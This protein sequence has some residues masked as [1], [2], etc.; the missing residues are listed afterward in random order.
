MAVEATDVIIIGAGLTGLSLAYELDQQGLDVLVLEARDRIGGRINT[1]T[2]SDGAPVEMGA[3]WFF[4]FFQN[5]FKKMKEHNLELMPQYMKGDTF[6]EFSAREAPRRSR[7]SVD[8]DSDMFRIK[9]GT[10]NIVNTLYS[11]LDPGKVLL[12]QVVTNINKEDNRMVVVTKDKSYTA[13]KVVTTIP[14]QLLAH[15]VKFSPALPSDVMEVTKRTHTWMGDSMK[16]AITY[17]KPFWREK[18]LAGALYSNAGPFVQMYDQTST[19]GT[20]FALVGFMDESIANLPEKERRQRAVKQLVRVFG[21]EAE[22]YLDYKDT[23]WGHEQFTMPRNVGR[24]SRHSNNGHSVY[25]KSYMGGSLY[26][27]GTETSSHAGGYMEGAV[28]SATYLAK[29]VKDDLSKY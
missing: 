1:Y 13:R 15:T 28:T 6:S 20:K 29:A 18:G 4:P 17:A 12:K 26:I 8:D 21:K 14:P 16:G 10:S 24:L 7:G 3:T 11:K 9:G 27:G 5:L 23:F 22:N 2:T 19:D 25:K